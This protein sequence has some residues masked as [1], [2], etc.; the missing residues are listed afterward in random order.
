MTGNAEQ[1]WAMLALLFATRV[2]LGFQFQTMASVGEPVAQELNVGYASIGTLIGLFMIPGLVLSIPAGFAGRYAPDKLLTATGLVLLAVGG[3]VAALSSSFALLS[4]GRLLCGAGF[5]LCSIYYTKMTADWFAGHELA[6]AMAVLVTSWATGIAMGQIAHSWLALHFGWRAAFLAATVHCAIGAAALIL[7]YRTPPVTRKAAA[8]APPL[9]R[10][11]WRLTLLASLVWT[12]F[13]AGYVV[14]LSFAPL[15]LEAGGL[16]RLAAAST[17]SLSSWVILFSAAA[18]GQLA[19]RTGHSTLILSA[20]LVSAMVILFLLPHIEWAVLLAIGFGLLGMAPAGL[21]MALTERAMA[22]EKRALGMGIFFSLY[23]LLMAPT[24]A[25][26]GWLFDLTHDPKAPILFAI[27]L[28]GLALSAY[29]GF[30]L[31]EQR[32]ATAT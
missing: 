11:E 8:K 9:S 24:P 29:L 21:I 23:F 16:D 15:L 4:V 31:T 7:L 19:D 22:A 17:V 26:A 3:A 10:R 6:T 27:G 14:Y 20:G 2:G 28:Y 12:A 13:N 30:R 18:C 1:R 5:V 25:I 32:P